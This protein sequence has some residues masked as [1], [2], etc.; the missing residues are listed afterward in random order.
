MGLCNRLDIFQEQMS[1]L[2][3][4]L[5]YTCT[6]IDDILWLTK[7]TFMDH[8]SKLMNDLQSIQK[9]ELKVNLKMSFIAK[10]KLKYF[11]VTGSHIEVLVL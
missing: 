2:M 3:Q 11:V 9:A 8:L 5:E 1:D 6:Y 4:G 7:D 10:T